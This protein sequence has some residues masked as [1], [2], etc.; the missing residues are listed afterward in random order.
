LEGPSGDLPLYGYEGWQNA[1]KVSLDYES[2]II[3][4]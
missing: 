3:E 1:V 2:Y 4:I